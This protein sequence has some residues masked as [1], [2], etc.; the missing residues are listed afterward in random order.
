MLFDGNNPILQIT[1]VDHM[2]WQSGYFDV[3]P[4]NYSALAFRIKGTAQISA[5]NKQYYINTN[6]ILYLPQNMKYSA[7]YTD[8]ELIVIH[9]VS[10][11]NDSE[12]EVYSFENTEKIYKLFLSALSFWKNKEH[13]FYSYTLAQL[14]MILGTIAEKN[15]EAVLPQHFLKALSFINANYKK[16]D[17]N[18]DMI[19]RQGG[20]S[21]TMLRQL[22]KKYYQ[23]TPLEYILSLRLEYARSL[24]SN[25]VSIENAAYDSG[26]NDSK[27]FARVVKKHFGCTPRELKYYGK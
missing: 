18:I 3:L 26:F 19:C 13:G 8:T 6:D 9:F 10:E 22:F 2:H 1:G 24:I 20:I 27:Y 7:E 5:E 23:K 4:R 17:L 16:N 15:A 21:A 11:K 25:G 12:I 14:Y